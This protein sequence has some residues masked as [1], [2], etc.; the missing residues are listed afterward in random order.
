MRVHT[1]RIFPLHPGQIDQSRWE[2]GV[3]TCC[4]YNVVIECVSM[5]VN[6]PTVFEMVPSDNELDGEPQ[7]FLGFDWKIAHTHTYLV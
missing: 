5:A 6:N 3:V 7:R 4:K 2:W 1:E